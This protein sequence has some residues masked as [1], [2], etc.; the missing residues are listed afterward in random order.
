MKKLLMLLVFAMFVSAIAGADEIPP[1]PGAN[2]NAA[3]ALQE[4]DR[5]AEDLTFDAEDLPLTAEDLPFHAVADN[6]HNTSSDSCCTWEDMNSVCNDICGDAG[7]SSSGGWCLGGHC[8]VN[9][10]CNR[11]GLEEPF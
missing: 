8:Q 7:W 10:V 5:R 2:D 4:H 6:P 1:T 3:S 9:C 11:P